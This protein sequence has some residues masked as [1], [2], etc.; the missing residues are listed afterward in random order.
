MRWMEIKTLDVAN[1]PG[2]RVSLFVSGCPHH[3]KGCFNPES[4]D[5]RAGHRFTEGV[6]NHIIELLQNPHYDGFSVLGGEPL[7]PNNVVEVYRLIK[8]VK[9]SINR[10]LSIWVWTGYTIDHFSFI[11]NY[12]GAVDMRSPEN[13]YR[14]TCQTLLNMIDVLVDGPFIEE[15]KDLK[16]QYCGSRNQR[17][18]NTKAY[19]KN[20]LDTNLWI[21]KVPFQYDKY[22]FDKDVLI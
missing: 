6:A 1:G 13:K 18:I 3:C 22:K 21:E 20:M 11:E 17:L 19:F 10:D 4:W 9:E 5:Y 2:C 12:F 8:R 7:C 15:E 14:A 16:L